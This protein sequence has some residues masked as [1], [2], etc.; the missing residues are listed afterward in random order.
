MFG[1]LETEHDHLGAQDAREDD[2]SW[3]F[4]IMVFA[5]KF[6]TFVEIGLG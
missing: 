1:F 3:Q 2:H 6:V 4:L 5:Q